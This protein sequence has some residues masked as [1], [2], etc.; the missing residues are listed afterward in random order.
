MHSLE[1]SEQNVGQFVTLTG[2]SQA[3]VSKHLATLGAAGMVGRRKEG[4]N[5]YYSISDPQ[6]SEGRLPIALVVQPRIQAGDRRSA[7]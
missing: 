3:N 5:A 7:E 2:Q 6:I 1:D 4:L